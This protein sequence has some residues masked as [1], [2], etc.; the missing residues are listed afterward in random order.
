MESKILTR[1]TSKTDR[2]EFFA[3]VDKPFHFVDSGLDNVYLVGIKYFVDSDGNKI[4]EI[5][6]I[7][8]L[9]QLIARDIV[10]SPRDLNGKEIKFLRKRLGKKATEYCSYLG[11]TPETLSRVEN[12]HQPA[13]IQTQKMVRLAYCILSDDPNLIQCAKTILESIVE[14]IKIL[15]AKNKRIVLEIGKNQEWEEHLAA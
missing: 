4:A 13:G 14:D 10:L 2:K 12:D 5:P 1:A 8:Q 9:M 7:K 6:A 3:T 11:I 15:K